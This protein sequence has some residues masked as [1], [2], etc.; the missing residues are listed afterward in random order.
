MR[1]AEKRAQRQR[2]L[3]WWQAALPYLK[4]PMPLE[5]FIG[6]PVD[7]LTRVQRFHERWEKLDQALIRGNSRQS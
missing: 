7:H 6:A 2:E 1:G 3:V 5:T 4:K